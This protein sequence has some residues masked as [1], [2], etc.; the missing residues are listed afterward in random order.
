MFFC[1][2]KLYSRFGNMDVVIG[3][4]PCLYPIVERNVFFYILRYDLIE[5]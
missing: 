1:F 5:R 4:Y 3:R 2:I